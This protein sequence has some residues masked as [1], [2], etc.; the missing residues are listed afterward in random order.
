[1]LPSLV[2]RAISVAV[3]CELAAAFT[4]SHSLQVLGLVQISAFFESA[5]VHKH[6]I[7]TSIS[8]LDNHTTFHGMTTC[9][10][11]TLFEFLM[12]QL[13]CSW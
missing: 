5:R 13:L 1:M 8:R 3:G 11:W 10:C 9:G 6:E 4:L 2:A 12:I 7:L